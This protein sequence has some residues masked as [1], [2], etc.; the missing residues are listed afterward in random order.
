M[1]LQDCKARVESWLR[2]A[3]AERSLES[4]EFYIAQL[5]P[6]ELKE[7]IDSDNPRDYWDA[8]GDIDFVMMAADALSPHEDISGVQD[9]EEA[10]RL[11]RRVQSRRG[12][13]TTALL[14]LNSAPPQVRAYV[15]GEVIK[16]N[17][18]KFCKT[19]QEA[20]DTVRNYKDVKGINLGI[21]LHAQSLLYVVYV[22]ANQHDTD[23]NFYPKGKIMKS[24]HFKE[25]SFDLEYIA[26]LEADS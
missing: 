8:V 2:I 4:V 19:Q 22:T 15:L 5:L 10:M 6:S 1:T 26:E 18:T 25:P 11:I 13:M 24:I 16:S 17:F 9:D 23:G 20:E 12:V 3:G 14:I 7:L 21:R